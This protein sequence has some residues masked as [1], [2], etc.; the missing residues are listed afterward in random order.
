MHDGAMR[1]T[2]VSY[3]SNE[4][5][6]FQMTRELAEEYRQDQE[7]GLTAPPTDLRLTRAANGHIQQLWK[8]AFHLTA[9]ELPRSLSM[10]L[11]LIARLSMIASLPDCSSSTTKVV[12]QVVY[13]SVESLLDQ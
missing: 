12:K 2:T 9:P 13:L 11:P 1:W 6:R 7:S 10:P 8:A 4:L 5:V 3:I